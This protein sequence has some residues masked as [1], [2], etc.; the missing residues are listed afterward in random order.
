MLSKKGNRYVA[1]D[2]GAIEFDRK[3][4]N[5]YVA[6][7]PAAFNMASEHVKGR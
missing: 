5:R 3:K 6:I 1:F 7:D 2:P 4:G